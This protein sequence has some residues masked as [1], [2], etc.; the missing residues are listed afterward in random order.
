MINAT[1]IFGN[2]NSYKIQLKNNL[3]CGDLI[4]ILPLGI[5][6]TYKDVLYCICNGKL[7]VGE[8]LNIPV[9]YYNV[10]DNEA[11]IHLILKHTPLSIHDKFVCSK[12]QS[13]I[14]AK[15]HT[16]QGLLET[17]RSNLV[18]LIDVS[19]VI[20]EADLDQ[21]IEPDQET[22][23]TCIVCS[24]TM[25]EMENRSSIKKCGHCFHTTCITQWL[26]VANV[27]CPMCN[28]DVRTF[29]EF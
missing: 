21:Y 13:W 26:T 4:Y 7:L 17:L 27:K 22:T 1:V 15:Y 11:T 6:K 18:N 3:S 12:Y 9:S 5:N 29:N 19:V 23:D 8:D 28:I 14:E 16:A 24:A 25:T 2:N 20:A 10:I